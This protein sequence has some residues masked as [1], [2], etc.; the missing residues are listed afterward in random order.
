MYIL[1]KRKCMYSLIRKP[2]VKAPRFRRSEYRILNADFFKRFKEQYPQYKDVKISVLKT[3]ISAF[4]KKV[5]TAA[6]NNRDGVE[7]PHGLGF[8]FIG[9]CEEPKKRESLDLKLSIEYNK[10]IRYRNFETDGRIAKIFYT[11]FPNKYKFKH[12]N[13]WTFKGGR[14]FTRNVA[15]VFKT[16]WNKYIKID[17]NQS[18]VKMFEN[19]Y[20]EPHYVYEPKLNDEDYNEFKID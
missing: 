18:I 5:Y 13:I 11:N 7:F 4:H 14:P 16:M 12:S 19:D 15:K 20:V 6:I 10:R 3:I 2:D 8:C 17:S 1:I 9:S